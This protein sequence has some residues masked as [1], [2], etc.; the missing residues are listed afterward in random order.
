MKV[1][2][3]CIPVVLQLDVKLLKGVLILCE[4]SFKN[5]EKYFPVVL[6]VLHD[7]PQVNI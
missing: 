3:Q 1:T 2:E 5:N 7:L 6:T 4:H